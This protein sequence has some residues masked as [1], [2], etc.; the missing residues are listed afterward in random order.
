MSHDPLDSL[1]A[2]ITATAR[3]AVARALAEAAERPDPEFL[4]TAEAAT[5]ARVAQAT[6]RRWTREGRLKDHGAGR[7][8][9]VASAELREL[10]R[11]G[12]K[13]QLARSSPK[14]PRELTPE[15]QAFHDLGIRNTRGLLA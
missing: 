5:I 10:L 14:R 9:R 4:S 3:E 2:W 13:R 8:V 11:P 15:E 6:I 7:E 12:R 1:R